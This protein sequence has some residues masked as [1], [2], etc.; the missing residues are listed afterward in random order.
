MKKRV[1]AIILFV[2]LSLTLVSGVLEISKEPIIDVIIPETKEKAVYDFKI[3]NLGTEDDFFIYSLVG[4]NIWP[5]ESFH[6]DSSEVKS[7]R[8]EMWPEQAIIDKG[9]TFN[10]V[11]KIKN[12][13]GD[14]QEDTILIRILDLS[15][16][17]EINSYTIS[18]ESDMAVVYVKNKVSLPFP[19]VQARFTSDFFDFEK[20]F[21]LGRYDKKEFEIPTNKDAMKKLIAG[22]YILTSDVETYGVKEKIE[23]SFRFT[24]K[25]EIR[26]E[27][28]KKG[29]LISRAEIKKINEGN[30]P[31]VVQINIKKNIISRLFTSFNAEPVAVERESFAV[32]YKF[33]QEIGPSETF[34][35][36]ATTFWLYP[37]VLIIAIVLVGYLTKAYVSSFLI[38]K[39]RVSFVKTK[40]G[41][42]AL[43]III[44]ARAK[45]FVEK[46]NIVDK[47]PA[48]VKVHERFGSHEPDKIDEKNR[49]LE[50]YVDSLQ[51]GEERVFSY[52]IYSKVY[53]MGKFEV[54]RATAVFEI[55]SKIHETN[56]NK[57]FFVTE[58]KK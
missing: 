34:R 48:L 9:G 46:I 53:P 19:N 36:R 11:Y 51:S 14:I 41:E 26:T 57:V 56:S 30:L 50:W 16:A 55:E 54:P 10:F 18:F 6:I 28:S 40:G 45:K 7:V 49:R 43:K 32:N 20:N 58:P 42:F 52:I 8:V 25:Q 17:I 35:V 27:E 22:S 39:K 13:F 3:K 15:D 44:V 38:L 29:F 37:L 47:I 33:Q 5:N 2:F 24:E 23:N 31:S 1:F 21:S 4:V 12:S